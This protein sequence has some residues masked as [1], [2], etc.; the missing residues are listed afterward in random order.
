MFITGPLLHF[1]LLGAVTEMAGGAL[2]A[3]G[4]F[5]RTVAIICSGGMMAAYFVYHTPE[6][7]WP[8]LYKSEAELLFCFLLLYIVFVGPG[9]FYVRTRRKAMLH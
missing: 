2:L 8:S 6:R 5:T 7:L 4:I 9:S 3:T 1:Y